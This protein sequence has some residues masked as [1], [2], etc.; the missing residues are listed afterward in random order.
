MCAVGRTAEDAGIA[1]DIYAH[2]ID[3]IVRAEGLGGWR[4]APERD[5]FDVEYWEMEQAKLLHSKKTRSL[6]GSVALVTGA[7]SGIGKACVDSLLDRGCSCRRVGC[8]HRCCAAVL[9][10]GFQRRRLRLDR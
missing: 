1:S 2:T 10:S 3:M 4:A 7:A 9:A 8:Q 6:T 5:F